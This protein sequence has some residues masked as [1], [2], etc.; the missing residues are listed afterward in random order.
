M[1]K[2]L[3]A[4]LA[5][6]ATLALLMLWSV[7]ATAE[8]DPVE[9][10]LPGV[11]TAGCPAADGDG[12]A[13]GT[14]APADAG[15]GG[16]GTGGTGGDGDPSTGGDA[17]PARPT[18][19][20]HAAV[21]AYGP[22][23]PGWSDSAGGPADRAA[24]IESTGDGDTG[25]VGTLAVPCE[26]VPD[27]LTPLPGCTEFEEACDALAVLLGEEGCPEE[28][29][30]EQLADLFGI[31]CEEEP[32]AT[33]EE[34]LELLGLPVEQC[35]EEPPQSCEEFAELLGVGGC[36]EIPCLDT[37][38]APGGAPPPELA[39]LFEALAQIGIEPCEDETPTTP[40]GRTPTPT[41]SGGQQ[42]VFYANCDDARAKGAAPVHAGQPGYR[43]ALDRDGDG[44]GCE[45]T[46]PTTTY[47][48]PHQPSGK[49]AYTGVDV[50]SHVAAGSALV[51]LGTLTLL[52]ARRPG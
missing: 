43:P 22:G 45:E 36:D 6:L 47:T 30:C 38:H 40:P 25:G 11:V 13:A 51:A 19:V 39:P 17:S 2:V 46:T 37:S 14:D 23:S 1:S 9:V 16:P 49:L 15:T 18:P 24:A 12:A 52:G 31:D 10:C 21:P 41:P 42:H 27:P 26:E 20:G 5:L 34:L 35:P 3:R 33:C 32:P 48:S 29:T 28:L 4:P 8:E 50:G 7:P 44:I